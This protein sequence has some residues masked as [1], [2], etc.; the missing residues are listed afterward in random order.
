[1]VEVVRAACNAMGIP[2][3]VMVGEN[4]DPI[5]APV[6]S[7]TLK[8]YGGRE[9][10]FNGVLGHSHVVPTTVRGPGDPGPEPFR[11]LLRAGFEAVPSP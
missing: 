10:V 2:K 5:V 11:A 9:Q 8:K 6:K 7:L 4:G 3:R 1:M